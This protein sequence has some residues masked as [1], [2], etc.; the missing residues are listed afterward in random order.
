LIYPNALRTSLPS[1]FSDNLITLLTYTIENIIAEKFET[2][3]DRGEL[4]GRMRDLVDIYLLMENIGFMLDR[5]LLVNTIIEVSKDRGTLAN[6]KDSS[7]IMQ[8]LS[9]SKIFN[10]NFTEYVEN[11]YPD[12]TITLDLV[13]EKFDEILKDLNELYKDRNLDQVC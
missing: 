13:F 5:E 10:T 12:I 3:L 2:T 4:N 8:S 6:L 9:E 1:L 11:N 7:E